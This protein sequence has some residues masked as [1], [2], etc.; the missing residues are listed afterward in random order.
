MVN[1]VPECTK[2][3]PKLSANQSY[4]VSAG[5]LMIRLTDWFASASTSGICNKFDVTFIMSDAVAQPVAETFTLYVPASFI[6]NSDVV[7]PSITSLFRSH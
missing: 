4:C 7:S 5:L 6:F 3:S 1:V 2:V